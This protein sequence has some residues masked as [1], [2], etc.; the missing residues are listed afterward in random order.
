MKQWPHTSNQKAEIE[1]LI[2][3]GI[4]SIHFYTIHYF[5]S[6]NF[7]KYFFAENHHNYV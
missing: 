6:F 2:F 1:L 4:F 5:L 3:H 7:G